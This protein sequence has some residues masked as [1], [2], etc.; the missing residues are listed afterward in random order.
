[1]ILCR[2]KAGDFWHPSSLPSIVQTATS[3]SPHTKVQSRIVPRIINHLIQSRYSLVSYTMHSPFY[4]W[5]PGATSKSP[6]AR[7]VTVWTCEFGRAILKL[8]LKRFQMQLESPMGRPWCQI[9]WG[10]VSRWRRGSA[11]LAR[12]EKDESRPALS[13]EVWWHL[14]PIKSRMAEQSSSID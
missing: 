14:K 4:G 3:Y 8:Q 13:T 12:L 11:S 7:T 10:R 9:G 5:N 2:W 6:W 1:M